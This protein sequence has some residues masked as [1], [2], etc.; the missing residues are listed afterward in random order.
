MTERSAPSS[1][2]VSA[3]LVRRL[4]EAPPAVTLLAAFAL[5]SVLALS[6][7][8]PPGPLGS[9]VTPTWADILLLPFS[10]AAM[11]VLIVV[12]TVA[13]ARR[14][15]GAERANTYARVL[16]AMAVA[17]AIEVVL[18]AGFPGSAGEL[19]PVRIGP[20]DFGFY[21]SGHTLRATV[22]TSAFVV[23]GPLRDN[24]RW[25]LV[26]VVPLGVGSMLVAAGGHF[27]VDVAG[28]LL[29]GAAAS[30]WALAPVVERRRVERPGA[31]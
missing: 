25:A 18:K 24:W 28:G 8:I 14:K 6:G 10:G 26:L 5:F 22:L 16:A 1:S 11:L 21:P 20:V 27:P 17:V 31:G 30:V 7:L 19:G 23:L 12:L 3:P 29:L 13:V 4:R 2:P 15:I 9:W